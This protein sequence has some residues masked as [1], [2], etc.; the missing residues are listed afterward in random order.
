MLK[1]I[2]FSLTLFLLLTF[3]VVT[4]CSE[5]DEVDE[6]DELLALDDEL[7]RETEAGG[8]KFS[9]AETLTKAQRIV[10]E[11]NNE[12][13]ERIVNGYEFVLVLGYA[14]WCS[15]SAELMPHF[16]E[17]ANSLKD[18]GNSLVLAKV[19]GDRFT[20]AASFL[21]IKGYPTLLLFVNGTSQPYSGGFTA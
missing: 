4:Q 12:N 20:K 21:G 5:V 18:L 8:V 16:A 10:F 17:A 6:F 9:E 13:S 1:F 3:N 14:P 7:E 15:R 19:D 2:N 11:L